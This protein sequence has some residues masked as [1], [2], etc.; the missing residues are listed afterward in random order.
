LS[1][2]RGVDFLYKIWPELYYGEIRRCSSM[3]EHGFRKA[4]VEGSNPSIGFMSAGETY[5]FLRNGF[6]SQGGDAM[7]KKMFLLLIR[8]FTICLGLSAGV[9]LVLQISIYKEGCLL[10]PYGLVFIFFFGL[11][12]VQFLI[13]AGIRLGIIKIFKLR[14]GHG[15]VG[16]FI[17][18]LLYSLGY[19]I[20]ADW[21]PYKVIDNDLVFLAV[22]PFFVFSVMLFVEVLLSRF[23]KVKE[24][25]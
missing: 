3:V 14:L 2:L 22:L 12:F 21:I 20:I 13:F 9:V 24:A 5:L 6:K 23:R 10:M 18:A 19:G 15:I 4:G 17:I 8:L 11:V 7:L 25:I 16:Y 1:T